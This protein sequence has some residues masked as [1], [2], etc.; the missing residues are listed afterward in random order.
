M[1]LHD[2]TNTPSD[3]GQV[4]GEAQTCVSCCPCHH[5]RDSRPVRC[6]DCDGIGYMDQ[7]FSGANFSEGHG[8]GSGEDG[9]PS[10]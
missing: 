1:I 8:E 7:H 5:T 3:A 10:R 6:R 4:C 2:L 9:E